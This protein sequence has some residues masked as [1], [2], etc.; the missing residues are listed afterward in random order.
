[1]SDVYLVSVNVLVEANS[2][3]DAVM[4]IVEALH[5]DDADVEVAIICHK[6]TEEER[7]N[8]CENISVRN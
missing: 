5:L 2:E 4:D 7:K 8:R 3:R 6:E 1:M